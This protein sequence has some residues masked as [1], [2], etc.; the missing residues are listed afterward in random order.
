MPE[1]W[2]VR[3]VDWSHYDIQTDSTFNF[4]P[5]EGMI[6]GFL[7]KE[8]PDYIVLAHQQFSKENQVRF[9]SVITK[10]SIVEVVKYNAPGGKKSTT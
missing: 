9:T 6:V 10:P 7:L 2:C 5:M 3:A 1:I 4:E 8:T